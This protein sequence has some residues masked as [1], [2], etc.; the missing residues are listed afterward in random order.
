MV[1]RTKGAPP[2]ERLHGVVL[3][4]LVVLVLLAWG[5]VLVYLGVHF[6]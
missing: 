4:G 1:L 6:L 3:A 5:V 2:K